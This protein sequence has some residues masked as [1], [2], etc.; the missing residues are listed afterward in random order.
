MQNIRGYSLD[1]H[2]FC[3]CLHHLIPERKRNG[4]KVGKVGGGKVG[5]GKVGEVRNG[6]GRRVKEEKEP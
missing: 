5:G 4:K 3:L 2:Q 1:S 6:E